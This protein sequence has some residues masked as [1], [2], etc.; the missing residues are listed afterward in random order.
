[1]A[2]I[3]ACPFGMVSEVAELLFTVA[4][5]GTAGPPAHGAH[6]M[7]SERERS[8]RG[9]GEMGGSNSCLCFASTLRGHY[10]PPQAG[11]P[12]VNKVL[13]RHT[14][15]ASLGAWSLENH[16]DK[17]ATNSA[18]GKVQRRKKKTP[19]LRFA[20]WNVRTLCPGLTTDL[21]QTRLAD[22]GTIREANYT[23]FWQ[24]KPSDEPR[25]HGVGFAVKNTLVAFIEPPSSG[26]ERILALR[27]STS[28]GTAK[29]LAK[30]SHLRNAVYNTAITSYGKESKN[31]NW[32]EANWEEMEPMTEA[33]R[34]AL[35]AY[36]GCHLLAEPL[37]QY[38]DSLRNRGILRIQWQD[39]VPNTEVLE[40]TGMN[41]MFSILSER[42]LRW[43]GHVRRMDP[44]CIPKDLLYGKLV[45]GARLTGRPRLRYK[46]V[47]KKD[48]KMANINVNNWESYADD[49][50]AW[51]LAVRQGAQKA[52]KVRNTNLAEKRAR[53]KANQQ[54]PQ[55]A[56]AFTCSKCNRD[57]HS[58]IGL[59]SQSQRCR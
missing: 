44:G 30:W 31:T 11:Q 59:F 38:T 6:Q 50:P 45:E 39:K 53:R 36:K 18:P 24:G 34:K 35:L 14:L 7:A 16:L 19:D 51:R 46:D 20:S 48:M 42:H 56:S 1:M 8:S 26:T 23:F 21:Q 13:S 33:K 17:Q 37:H 28:S 47:C 52:E 40:R 32:Y 22:S 54:Q 55:Q 41:S 58:R 4:F 9:E 10:H 57:C 12:P 2:I 49:H 27:L 3:V 5:H 15:L 43:L 29:I 25:Q